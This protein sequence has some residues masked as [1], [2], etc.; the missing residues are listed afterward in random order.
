MIAI[1]AILFFI[2]G[3]TLGSFL[4]VL[5][6]RIHSEKDGIFFGRSECPYC[7]TKLAIRD[8]FPIFSYIMNKGRC[9]ICHKHISPHYIL[10]EI[11]TGIIFVALFLKAP[12]LSLNADWIV[13]FNDHIF[14]DFLYFALISFFMI[15]I[16]FYDLK[17]MEIPQVFTYPAIIISIMASLF[18]T[19]PGIESSLIGVGIAIVFFGS[20]VW[21]TK[22]RWMGA[23]DLQVG[24]LMGA[25]L[26]WQHLLMA[27]I[28]SY[29]TGTI[30]SSYLLV[31]KKVTGKT[32][33]PFAPFL[34]TGFF[35]TM[36]LGDYIYAFYLTNL[37]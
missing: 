14:L 17:H 7:H 33:I 2:I 19:G 1:L 15:G 10:L 3:T 5:I 20:Q 11:L 26:G 12:F 28:L 25:F 18:F 6:Y 37:L 9:R 8:L 4:S 24:I 22:E 29:L 34:V 21:L 32:P 30:V 31:S 27:L 35:I 13:Y 16:F 23:G 36:F